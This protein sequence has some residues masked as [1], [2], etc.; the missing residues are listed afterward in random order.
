MPGAEEAVEAVHA[1]G[2]P[3][4]LATST[5]G[6]LFAHKS[7]PHSGLFGAFHAIVVGDDPAVRQGKPAPDI[8]LEAAR[9]IGATDMAGCL[10]VED[11]PNGVLGALAAGMQVVW[12]PDAG[13]LQSQPEL[14]V[15]PNVTVLRSLHE[16]IALLPA[17]TTR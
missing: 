5:G 8:F 17:L 6:S 11:S 7:A 13:L 15:H 12:I 1:L 14:W 3:M 9:R 2:I 10:V 4:A 16:L